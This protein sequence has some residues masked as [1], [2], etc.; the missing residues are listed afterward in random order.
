MLLAGERIER[1][2]LDQAFEHPLVH[3]AKIGLLAE[4]VQRVDAAEL[5]AHGE[6]RLDGAFADVLH[7]AQPE[8]HAVLRDRER[9]L[10]AVDVGLQDGNAELAAL[11]EV[12]RELVGVRRF[13]GQQR[14]HEVPRK[15]GLQVRG[16]VGHPRVGRRVRLV[17]AVPGEELHQV[18]NLGGLLLVDAVLP[19]PVHEGFALLGHD[20]GIFLAHGLS[21]HV[22][23]AH[24]EPGQHRGDA[25]DLFLIG[26]DAVG[27]AEDRGELR[28][29]VLDL[30]LAL[31]ARDEVV[32]H[33]AL[34]RA[35]TVERV[36]RDQVVE[37]LR[38][39]LA[40]QLAHARALELEHAVGLA[41]PEQLV[42]LLVVE[43]DGVDVEV[44]AFG[45]LDLAERVADQGQR[46]QAEEVHL[47]EAD[48]LDLLHRPLRDDFVLLALVE[49]NE[50]G[51]RP[52]R[53]D[54][55]GGVHRGVPGHAFE[56]LG[57]GRAAP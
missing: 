11:A 13:D 53:D 39:G 46:A 43:R 23:L 4:R 36:Q 20:L 42:G 55:A 40:Q 57:D 10:A 7:G 18:E 27:V 32:D 37:P 5:L 50:L 52:G 34:E 6:N 29:L 25:H 51:Q 41:V 19:R 49:R 44:D 14:R 3:Q 26:D 28:Q 54:D 38:L 33:P 48:P 16:L 35:G 8:A 17:E 9:Q 24:R 56:T 1:A 45:A 47:Q 15:V 31:L 12:H 22:G 21:Q 2:G 30:G